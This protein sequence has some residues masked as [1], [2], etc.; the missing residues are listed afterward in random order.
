MRAIVEG[1]ARLRVRGLTALSRYAPLHES[2]LTVAALEAVVVPTA[3]D[4]L[5][6]Q[7]GEHS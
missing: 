4:E 6:R 5:Q 7:G 1:F 3:H 2:P